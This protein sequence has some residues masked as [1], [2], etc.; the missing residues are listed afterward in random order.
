MTLPLH[1]PLGT[2]FLLKSQ[3]HP[4][5]TNSCRVP[6]QGVAG[7]TM[8]F[9]SYGGRDGHSR[10][11]QALQTGTPGSPQSR[12]DT[13][14]VHRALLA[15]HRPRGTSTYHHPPARSRHAWTYPRACSSLHRR[16]HRPASPAAKLACPCLPEPTPA[17]VHAGH[18]HVEG[19][20]LPLCRQAPRCGHVHK[21][22]AGR[23]LRWAVV[24]RA[25]RGGCIR[26]RHTGRPTGARLASRPLES[27]RR[28]EWVRESG[29]ERATRAK[30]RRR[31]RRVRRVS[32]ANRT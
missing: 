9:T 8:T 15:S 1:H 20:A 2:L 23:A 14:A 27:L 12:G 24:Q 21:N 19:A 32:S 11:L 10:A 22:G 6:R 13:A 28:V 5:F 25:G 4:P 31:R 18:G 30:R 7:S 29:A 26:P 16:Q 17:F 3:T